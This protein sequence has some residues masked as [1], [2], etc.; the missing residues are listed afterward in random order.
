MKHFNHQ[1]LAQTTAETQTLN[2][3]QYTWLMD[4]AA[5]MRHNSALEL[6]RQKPNKNYLIAVNPIAFLQE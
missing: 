1:Q 5:K 6:T 2:Y 4:P 3:R